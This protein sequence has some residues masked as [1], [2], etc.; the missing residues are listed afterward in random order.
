MQRHQQR[1]S[2]NTKAKQLQARTRLLLLIGIFRGT[3]SLRL[4]SDRHQIARFSA[5]AGPEPA[6]LS[7]MDYSSLPNDPD[8]PIGSSPWQSSPQP[9]S[10]AFSASEPSSAPSSPLA[11]HSRPKT[12]SAP[13]GDQE[14]SDEN[15]RV[16]RSI[17]EER[18]ISSEESIAQPTT[19]G[20]AKTIPE[21]AEQ[22]PQ[23]Q[24]QQRQQSR[25]S[26][27]QQRTAPN[28]Y[29]GGAA[30]QPQRQ[31]LPQYK[32]Q[33]KITSLE[34]TGRKDPVLKFDVHVSR[35]KAE[36]PSGRT[37][38]GTDESTKISNYSIPRCQTN[39]QRVHEIGRPPDLVESRGLCTRCSPTIKFSR[40]R[41]G[42]G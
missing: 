21:N 13:A 20:D 25:Q 8:H 7:M 27:Q 42:R 32:L 4:L 38:D 18:Q 41:H 39:I 36:Y 2:P 12:D 24:Q 17:D 16:S 22:P 1:P 37:N 23:A 28:R 35:E 29:H 5:A 33:A 9:T 11:K 31:N 19:N 30:R 6:S 3:T 26:Q 10:K 14:H 34:R 15:N 40:R